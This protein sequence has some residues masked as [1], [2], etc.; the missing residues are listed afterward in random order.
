MF[1]PFVKYKGLELFGTVE[2]AQGGDK[3]GVDTARKI[4]QYAGDVVYRFGPEEKFYVGARVNTVS[5]KL[6]NADTR[7]VTV[8]RFETSAGWFMTKNI[9]AKLAYTSQNYSGYSEFSGNSLNDLYG[10]KFNGLL[11]EAVITF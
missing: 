2:L 11:F 9:L 1:N 4:N 7:K 5:G 3:K 6:T 10:G 8:N